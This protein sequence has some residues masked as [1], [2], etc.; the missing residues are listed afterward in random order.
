MSDEIDPS[1]P[2]EPIEDQA[3]PDWARI[4]DTPQFVPSPPLGEEVVESTPEPEAPKVKTPWAGVIKERLNVIESNP[5]LEDEVMKDLGTIVLSNFETEELEFIKRGIYGRI[6]SRQRERTLIVKSGQKHEFIEFDLK[7]DTVYMTNDEFAAVQ[8]LNGYVA[9]LRVGFGTRIFEQDGW[10]NLPE[11]GGNKVALTMPNPLKSNDPIKQIQGELG[12]STEG[13]S[14]LWH[15]GLHL[16]MDDPGT[17]TQLA[18]ETKITDEKIQ[19]ARDNNGLVFSASSVYLNSAVMNY[20]LDT[21]TRSSVGTT[22]PDE[23]KK[24]ILLPDMEPMTLAAAAVIFP[25][26]YNLERPCLTTAKGCGHVLTR[27]VNLRRMLFVRHN[28]ITDDQFSLMAKRGARLDVKSVRAYQASLRP[29]VSR[30]VD[31]N[32]SLAIK[33]RIPTFADY[34]RQATAWMEELDHRARSI[35]TQGENGDRELFLARANNVAMVMAYSS[36]IEAVV[37]IDPNEE[38]GYKTRLTRVLDEEDEGDLEKLY[39]ADADLDQLLISFAKNAEYTAKIADGIETFINAITLATVAV[40]KTSCPKCGLP[41]SGD[42]LSK[43]PHL[44]SI[45]P[46]EVFFTLVHH[47]IKQAG[48]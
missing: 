5:V 12:M 34:E 25:K 8:N 39:Q 47:K 23:L 2:P 21:V 9:S 26:G 22:H 15:S 30:L 17:L 31:L 48:G 13:G 16:T 24:L 38:L 4:P 18:L 35:M 6:F 40:P 27:K 20:M 42:N 7:P 19:M 28:R 36:W 33:L 41:L 10:H 32:G 43:H 46:V 1:L 37:Q 11:R 44:V 29:E 3:Q 45:N 14:V